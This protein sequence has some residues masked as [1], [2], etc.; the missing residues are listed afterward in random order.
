M[1]RKLT[2]ILMFVVGVVVG[3]GTASWA[4]TIPGLGQPT[5]VTTDTA[6]KV[7]TAQGAQEPLTLSNDS[8]GL[9][10]TGKRHGRVVGTLVAKIDGRWVEVQFAP[11]DSFAGR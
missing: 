5:T 3:A 6:G 1:H 9:R 7:L 11:Q 10:V 2:V 8:L 4:G